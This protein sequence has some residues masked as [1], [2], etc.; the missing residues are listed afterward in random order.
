MVDT[1]T[2]SPVQEDDFIMI[3]NI[4]GIVGVG[5]VRKATKSDKD[6]DYD[7]DDDD[8]NE[9]H[10]VA[11]GSPTERYSNKRDRLLRGYRGV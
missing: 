7:D 5:D 6:D 3:D 1:P 10:E 4:D 11:V 8:D 2:A 9:F